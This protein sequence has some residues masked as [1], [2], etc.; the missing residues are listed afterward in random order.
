MTK[1][2]IHEQSIMSRNVWMIMIGI[3]VL[4]GLYTST[5]LMIQHWSGEKKMDGRGQFGDQFGAF[6]ALVS[7]LTVI[8]VLFS[9]WVQ[10][11][12]HYT[13]MRA[14]KEQHEQQMADAERKH[15]DIVREASRT[16]E[17]DCL[18]RLF[19]RKALIESGLSWEKANSNYEGGLEIVK[20]RHLIQRTESL[21]YSALI[22]MNIDESEL[23]KS[24]P[25]CGYLKTDRIDEKPQTQEEYATRYRLVYSIVN[26]MPWGI[27]ENLYAIVSIAKVA[28][29]AKRDK[30]EVNSDIGLQWLTQDDLSL[31]EMHSLID[32]DLAKSLRDLRW[33]AGMYE[34][35]CWNYPTG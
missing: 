15:N 22:I 21:I 4:I 14:A 23:K 35:M 31:L 26:F 33:T 5:P 30:D 24:V 28:A 27:Q 17:L 3:L 25:I 12:Q 9:I 8:A 13:E 10:R 7:M 11:R 19:D 2:S 16:R 1:Q 20:G 6:N 29:R 32:V 18:F 34:R